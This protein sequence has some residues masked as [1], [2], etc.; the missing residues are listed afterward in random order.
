NIEK[1]V[2]KD[3]SKD[4][5]NMNELLK[6]GLNTI[7]SLIKKLQEPKIIKEI[8]NERTKKMLDEGMLQEARVLIDLG[9][10]IP[11][12]LAVEVKIAQELLINKDFKKAK[13]T[14]LKASELAVLIQEDQIASFLENKGEQVG[15][16]PD[17]IKERENI[18]KEILKVT[19][20]IE[21]NKLYLYD[22]L[23]EPVDRLI[24][25]Y[26]DLEE[27]EAIS[28]LTK[29]KNDIQRASRLARELNG[30]K[31]KIRENLSKI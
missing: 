24:E 15:T 11:E 31:N 30:L 22:L 23:E 19:T 10:D 2:I 20:E 14:F 8:L 17:L 27:N 6:D 9:E 1:K 21:S 16:F 12:K 29:I 7:L 13:K 18:N 4:K 25:I 3:F 26:N 5:T 28:E